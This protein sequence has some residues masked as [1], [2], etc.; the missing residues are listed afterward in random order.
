MA[1]SS[2][3]SRAEIWLANSSFRS[4]FKLPEYFHPSLFLKWFPGH[5][6]KGI[7][8]YLMSIMYSVLFEQIIVSFSGLRVMQSVVRKC[9]CVLEVHDARVS[10][11]L[12][13]HS[14]TM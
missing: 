14:S 1:V 11:I 6:A 3:A 4:S 5:M 13:H 2:Y 12:Y 10:F 9:D 8:D 7:L